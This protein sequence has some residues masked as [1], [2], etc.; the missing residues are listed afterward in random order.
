MG[1]LGC[2]ESSAA[3]QAD[4]GHAH[5]RR[6]PRGARFVGITGIVG[7]LVTGL[8][9]VTGGGAADASTVGCTGGVGDTAGLVSAVAAANGMSGGGTVVLTGGCTYTFAQAND[10]TDGGNAL[11]AITGNVTITGNGSTITRSAASGTPLFRLLDVST[12][13]AKLI[14]NN[15]TLTNG[16]TTDNV[17][18]G[19]IFN[20]GTTTLNL[21]VVSGNTALGGGG[22][23]S[24]QGAVNVSQSTF[25]N[26]TATQALGGGLAAEGNTVLTVSQSTFLGN[27]AGAAGGGAILNDTTLTI[28]NSTFSANSGGT[29]GG[30]AIENFGS[31]TVNQSTFSGNQSPFGGGVHDYLHALTLKQTVVVNSTGGNCGGSPGVVDGGYNLEDGT[32][33][34][35]SAANHS[36]S[37][38]NAQL[39]PLANNG[40][41]TLTFAITS[42]SPAFNAIPTG[43]PGCGG[44]DQRGV[45][46]PQGTGCDIGSYELIVQIPTT[47]NVYSLLTTGLHPKARLTRSDTGA[48][49]AGQTI[50]FSSLVIPFS[51]TAVTN[52]SGDAECSQALQ[53]VIVF[54]A[55]FAGN[56]QYL[57]SSAGRL[58]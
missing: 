32:T 45:T 14:L 58:L 49:I 42:S 16:N 51:C 17:G 36:L 30:G 3:E 22:L 18:G 21:V 1:T 37:N 57:P 19:A 47:M 54:K 23:D 13:S 35:F 38:T 48:G 4:Y 7:M 53:L 25:A 26:N 43:T 28:T 11:P 20:R 15:L 40:G 9:V 29:S 6:N 8:A 55:T 39:G 33:C 50:T 56:A 34:G 46:R 31:G 5:R 10:A 41:P 2:R 44:T 12:P 27:S 24:N 52:S